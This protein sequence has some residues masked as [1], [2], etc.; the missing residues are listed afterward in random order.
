MKVSPPAVLVFTFAVD[1]LECFCRRRLP[2]LLVVPHCKRSRRPGA[3]RRQGP[4]RGGEASGPRLPAPRSD[5][6]QRLPGHRRIHSGCGEP[7]AAETAFAAALLALPQRF[8]C[9]SPQVQMA[10]EHSDFVM[11]FIC[12]SKVTQSPQFIHMTPGVQL[13]AG[14]KSAV[15]TEPEGGVWLLPLELL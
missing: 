8:A 14:G 10:E 2:D 1:S 11:G 15:K 5:E 9:L 7:F 6:L 4:L 13:E 3:W 12:C